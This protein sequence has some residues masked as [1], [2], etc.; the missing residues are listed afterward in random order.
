MLYQ[1]VNS[2]FLD[3]TQPICVSVSRCVRVY[4]CVCA[5]EGK[6]ESITSTVTRKPMVGKTKTGTCEA[7][8]NFCGHFDQRHCNGR[9]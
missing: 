9:L 8:K 3:P 1:I 5:V 6:N 2:K 4:V 7:G